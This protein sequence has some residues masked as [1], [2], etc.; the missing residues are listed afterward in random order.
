M[1]KQILIKQDAKKKIITAFFALLEKKHFSEITV[2]DIV[3]KA[4]V[5]RA[6]YYRN[7]D[8][9]EDIINTYLEKLRQEM[10]IFPI[11]KE[12]SFHN[13]SYENL[14]KRLEYIASQKQYISLLSRNGFS[15]FLLDESNSFAEILLGDMPNHSIERYNIYLVSGAL[16]NL[17]LQ[18]V[19]NDCK[20]PPEEMARLIYQWM[21]LCLKKN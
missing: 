19:K 12:L 8:I 1:D 21:N 2:T 10:S 3:R 15:I 17:I 9:K 16:L 7:F 4:G 5:A 18:W 6:T 11:T 14:V 13:F 20:E